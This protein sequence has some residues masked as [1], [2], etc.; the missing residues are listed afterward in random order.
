[1]LAIAKL[2]IMPSD[3]VHFG[4]A[5][6]KA[7]RLILRVDSSEYRDQWESIQTAQTIDGLRDNGNRG[8]T[9]KYKS[10]RDTTFPNNELFLYFEVR[11]LFPYKTNRAA[12]TGGTC[13]TSWVSGQEKPR[14][15]PLTLKWLSPQE[16]L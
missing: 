13:S 16:N 1:M 3:I 7:C 5:N 8:R 12:Q 4:M 14:T 11:P 9:S 6:P 10:T 2:L 15:T